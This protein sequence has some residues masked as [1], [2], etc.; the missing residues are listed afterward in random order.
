MSATT[1]RTGAAYRYRL[2]INGT[3]ATSARELET[4]V[5]AVEGWTRYQTRI[6]RRHGVTRVYIACDLG[7]VELVARELAGHLS[8]R[9]SP[10]V[11]QLE[12]T[13]WEAVRTQLAEVREHRKRV[14]RNAVIPREPRPVW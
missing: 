6:E 12:P 4:A 5:D 14:G 9:H 1:T 3:A 7:A 13:T 8:E 10:K 2:E 11:G